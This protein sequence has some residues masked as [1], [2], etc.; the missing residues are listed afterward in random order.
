MSAPASRKTLVA[1]GSGPF[2]GFERLKTEGKNRRQNRKQQPTKGQNL[3]TETSARQAWGSRS[4]TFN[5]HIEPAS[6][7]FSRQR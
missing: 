2:A 4:A 6:A 3:R 5:A 7:F 1:G